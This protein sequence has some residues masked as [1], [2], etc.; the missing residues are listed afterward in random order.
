MYRF[1]SIILI[2][3]FYNFYKIAQKYS[4]THYNLEFVK[5]IYCKLNGSLLKKLKAIEKFHKDHIYPLIIE[6]SIKWSTEKTINSSRM[7][8]VIPLSYF[9]TDIRGTI[10]ETKWIQWSTGIEMP[11]E[12]EKKCLDYLSLG[13]GNVDFIWGFDMSNRKEKIYLEAPHE[14]KIYSYVIKNE[15]ILETYEYTKFYLY[16]SKYFKFYYKRTDS[17]NQVDSYHYSLKNTID[18]GCAKIHFISIGCGTKT[19]YYYSNLK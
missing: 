17:K 13:Y 16:N 2:I 10:D 3:L 11:F 4:T 9:F 14:N 19:L 18:I 7:T 8:I 6:R 12:I 15:T 1:F 5:D